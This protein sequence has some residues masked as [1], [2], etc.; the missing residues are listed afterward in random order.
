[1]TASTRLF[2]LVSSSSLI[3]RRLLLLPPGVRD[4][5]FEGVLGT[6]LP[7]LR[8]V[9]G[10]ASSIGEGAGAEDHKPQCSPVF[11]ANRSMSLS[12][13]SHNVATTAMQRPSL[14]SLRRVLVSSSVLLMSL[15]LTVPLEQPISHTTSAHFM[16]LSDNAVAKSFSVGVLLM[17]DCQDEPDDF[18]NES[19]NGD[20]VVCVLDRSP[21]GLRMNAPDCLLTKDLSC[22]LSLI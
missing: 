17:I 16:L 21:D 11:T 10:G 3:T 1:M 7:L 2:F 9:L 4:G 20:M 22:V 13:T 12:V 5:V 15:C 6:D 8:G 18:D 14:L 19:S